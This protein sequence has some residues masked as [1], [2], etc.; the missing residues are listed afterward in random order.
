MI[1]QRMQLRTINLK[2]IIKAVC[3]YCFAFVGIQVQAQEIIPD[4]VTPEQP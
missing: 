4:E 3:I 2:F 1:L